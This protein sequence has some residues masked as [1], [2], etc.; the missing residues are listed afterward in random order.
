MRRVD[1][2]AITALLL[3]IGG[4]A[5]PGLRFV[6]YLRLNRELV[7]AIDQQ[8]HRTERE[9]VLRG[10]NPNTRGKGGSFPLLDAASSGDI[11]WANELLDHGA[12][13][14]MARLDNGCTP[15][16]ATICEDGTVVETLLRR[17]ARAD[18]PDPWGQTALTGAIAHNNVTA[19]RLLLTH[20]A[21][22][23][24][25]STYG[26]CPRAQT[27]RNRPEMARALGWQ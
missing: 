22:P 8:E 20:G 12:D 26:D 21:D 2:I 25:K 16:T 17:G 10:A 5:Y 9:L 18:A 27:I 11:G 7:A 6:R 4:A 15:L 14:N 3:V 19:A 23:D 13:V 24:R 1:T